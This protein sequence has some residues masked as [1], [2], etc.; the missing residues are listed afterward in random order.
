[1]HIVMRMVSIYC[2]QPLGTAAVIVSVDRLPHLGGAS[3][4]RI[5]R[6]VRGIR[7]AIS[8]RSER[9]NMSL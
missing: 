6:A 9:F 7:A 4:Q 1:M 5:C 2:K 8:L 3:H